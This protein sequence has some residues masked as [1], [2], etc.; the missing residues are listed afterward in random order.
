MHGQ[1]DVPDMTALAYAIAPGY[2]S[3]VDMSMG[4]VSPLICKTYILL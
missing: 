3:Q 2:H 1:E 4:T